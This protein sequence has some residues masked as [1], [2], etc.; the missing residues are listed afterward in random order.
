M[1]IVLRFS[2][3][4]NK[5]TCSFVSLLPLTVVLRLFFVFK[6]LPWRELRCIWCLHKTMNCV[7]SFLCKV[8][9][10]SMLTYEKAVLWFA[11]LPSVGLEQFQQGTLTMSWVSLPCADTGVFSY[12]YFISCVIHGNSWNEGNGQSLGVITWLAMMFSLVQSQAMA[13]M[14]D[15]MKT[16]SSP[17]GAWKHTE[18][19]NSEKWS[20]KEALLDCV[21]AH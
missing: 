14:E 17:H 13:L 6:T 18:S 9:K 8:L 4:E 11:G 5:F 16:L 15:N 19:F 21:P 20:P 3:S 10:D 1:K 12:L 2:G 7:C